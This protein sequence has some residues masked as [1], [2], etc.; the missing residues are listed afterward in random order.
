MAGISMEICC[1]NLESVIAAQEAGANRI[2]LCA[3]RHLGGTTPSYG[4]MEVV[5][6][7]LHTPVMVMIRPRGGDFLYSQLEIEVMIHDIQMAKELQ[8]TGVVMG[9]LQQNGEV[10]KAVMTQLI[11]IA[12]PMQVTF[13][14]AFDLTP[15]P[16]SSLQD[17]IELGVDRVLTSGQHYRSFEGM[18]VIKTLI[19]MAG[20]RI[21]VMPG[22]G[23][24]EYSVKE[25]IQYTGAKEFH[26]SASGNRPSTMKFKKGQVLMGTSDSEYTVEIADPTR[27]RRFRKIVDQLL[28]KD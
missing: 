6:K 25:I 9:V 13:H 2:E 1:Y 18:K 26:V 28:I 7:N 15:D 23:I 27:I 20:D 21:V 22:G 16:I 3:N 14:R 8:M 19:D 17:L 4:M 10:N 12:R 5:R 11:D 24:T